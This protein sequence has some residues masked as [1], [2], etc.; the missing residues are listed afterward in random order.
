M[1]SKRRLASGLVLALLLIPA[2]ADAARKYPEQ[3]FASV[4]EV[5]DGDTLDTISDELGRQR[6]DLRGFTA[7]NLDAPK[8][9]RERH[10]GMVAKLRLA[11]LVTALEGRVSLYRVIDGR[12]TYVDADGVRKPVLAAWVSGFQF[13]LRRDGYGPYS[14]VRD[15]ADPQW[16]CKQ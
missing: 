15:R 1:R 14:D 7:G 10:A 6:I 8:C 16:W 2:S 3:V 9:E 4:V 11:E 13:T 12:R 5:V